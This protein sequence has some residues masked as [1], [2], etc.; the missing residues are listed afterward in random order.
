MS[1]LALPVCGN[2]VSQAHALRR[3]QRAGLQR[4]VAAP[5]RRRRREV[6]PGLE[7]WSR[8]ATASARFRRATDRCRRRE[9]CLLAADSR[10]RPA[11]AAAPG[12]RET[13][14]TRRRRRNPVIASNGGSGPPGGVAGAKRSGRVCSAPTTAWNAE[15]SAGQ[16]RCPEVRQLGW[17]GSVQR[18][19][20]PGMP[21]ARPVSLVVRKCANL[22]GPKGR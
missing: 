5:A 19:R 11:G 13:T 17:T 12:A 18:R 20:R 8:P 6:E 2:A 21:S 3:T 16:P 4:S 15:C 1:G 10:R 14:S 9:R 7:K 22:D